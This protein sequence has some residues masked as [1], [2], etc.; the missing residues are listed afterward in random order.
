MADQQSADLVVVGAGT[1]GGWASTFAA[2]A[3][4]RRVVVVE[5]G[6]A[7]EGASSRAAGIVRA[8]GGTPATVALEHAPA[9]PSA[10][11][12]TETMA[13]LCMRLHGSAAQGGV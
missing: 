13:A 7:G 11:T 12:R 9:P 6:V 2:E 10:S 1:I 3:G 4:L 8:Q 5:R